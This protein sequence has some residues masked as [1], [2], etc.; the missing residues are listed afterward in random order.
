MTGCGAAAVSLVAAACVLGT[1]ALVFGASAGGEA[2]AA[3]AVVPASSEPHREGPPRPTEATDPAALPGD[4]MDIPQSAQLK[5][6]LGPP[7]GTKS[8]RPIA[9]DAT[10]SPGFALALEAAQAAVAA[11]LADG[12]SVAVAVTDSKGK[13]KVAFAPDGTRNNGV[14]MALRKDVTVVGFNMTTLQVRAK[15]EADASVASQIKPNMVM[16]PGGIP[17]RKGDTLLGAISASGATAYEEEKC[18]QAGLDRIQ[19]RL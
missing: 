7:A 2:T 1:P 5:V 10:P 19:S 11:C 17:I 16:L 3:P 8:T 18:A 15:I 13:L 6:P 4:Y 12:Y 14:Y 9:T